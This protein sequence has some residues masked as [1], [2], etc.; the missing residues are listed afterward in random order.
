MKVAVI[1]GAGAM[2]GVLGGTLAEAG[3]EV[4]LVDV[5]QEAVDRINT[6]G[7]RIE[8]NGGASRTVR[9]SATTDPASVGPVE[10]AIVFTKCY[11]TE[12]AV[13]S[14]APLIDEHTAVLSLQNGWGNA[15]RIAAIVGSER[16][17]AG[18]TYHSATVLQPGHVLH[19]GQGVTIIGELNGG[20]SGRVER[21]ATAFRDAGLEVS[22]TATVVDAIWSKL[23]LNVCTLPTSALLRFYA[24][25]LIEHDGT[26]ELMRVLLRETVAVAKAQGYGL[27]ENER[28]ETI[29]GL[30]GRAT[31]GKSSMLQ[32][33]E[34]GRRTEIDVINGA[35]VEAG[36]R[37]GVA[38]PFNQSMVWLIKA[39]EETF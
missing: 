12:N 36:R 38:T 4:V 27:D 22:P 29:T 35:V 28:W 33:V 2:G 21:I 19:A 17:L 8:D 39:L 23:A 5:A 7:L 25:Q 34:R 16:V 11:H 1:G 10:L 9:V 26:M 14:A 32:D 37:S 18:V 13:R 20:L 30:L 6:E 31:K 15:P 3:N 24:G